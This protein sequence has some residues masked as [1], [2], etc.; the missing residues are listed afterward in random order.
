MLLARNDPQHAERS[1]QAV[2]LRSQL[3]P[4]A[5]LRVWR[6]S[7]YYFFVF[8]GFVALALW[9]PYYLVEVYGLSIAAAG[10]LAALYTIPGSLFRLLG[11]ILSDRYGARRVMYWALGAGRVG[12]VH[13]PAQLS[14]HDLHDRGRTR[15]DPILA[16][17][18][19]GRFR[20]SD[21]GAGLCDVAGQ[22]GRV[23]AHRGL[24]SAPTWS[25]WSA[26]W[27]VSSCR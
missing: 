22:G 11:G 7:R 9:L 16:G 2:S 17:A 26:V 13:V 18:A 15:R 8:G 14:A 27:A 5:E 25:A 3:A 1:R 19:P 23:Q 24:L 21:H 10:V 12:R 4:L 20:A 6:F